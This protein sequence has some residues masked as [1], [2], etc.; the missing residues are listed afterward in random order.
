MG[1]IGS[2]VEELVNAMAT[3][4]PDNTAVLAL[5]VLLDDVAV[6]AEKCAWL[7]NLNGLVQAFTRSL[8]NAHCIRVGQSLVANVVCLVQVS[9]EAAVVQ[10]NVDVED[11]TVLEDSLIGNAVADDLVD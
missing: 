5:G 7:D 1:N 6:L 2:A 10:S 9:M 3:V 8:G 4:G 11:I